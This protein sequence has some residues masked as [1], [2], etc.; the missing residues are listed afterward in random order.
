MPVH[1]ASAPVLGECVPSSIT[2]GQ[3]QVLA[4]VPPVTRVVGTS[5]SARAIGLANA[6]AKDSSELHKR[7]RDIGL[8]FAKDLAFAG[9]KLIGCQ[10]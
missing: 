6:K 10:I 4:R 3:A 1:P 7:G 2:E 8:E 5:L 9:H